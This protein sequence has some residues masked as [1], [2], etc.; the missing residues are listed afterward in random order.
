MSA[1]APVV[2]S[3]S[4]VS[5]RSIVVLI[6]FGGCWVGGVAAGAALGGEVRSTGARRRCDVLSV[7]V[8]GI[9]VDFDP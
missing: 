4:C 9:A 8:W 3:S 5:E 2:G 7:C 6:L 1:N